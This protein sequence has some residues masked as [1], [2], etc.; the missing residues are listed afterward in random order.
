MSK[1]LLIY[2]C[3]LLGGSA[4]ADEQQ[5][6]LRTSTNQQQITTGNFEH[7][8]TDINLNADVKGMVSTYYWTD[9]S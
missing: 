9:W 6:T 7:N 2:G 4:V 5:S 8:V 3:A 1:L